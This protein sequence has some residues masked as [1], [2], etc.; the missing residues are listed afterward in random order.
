MIGFLF[1]LAIALP[2]GVLMGAWVAAI[3]E[4]RMGREVDRIF[5]DRKKLG[6]EPEPWVNEPMAGVRVC[7]CTGFSFS[8]RSANISDAS[9]RHYRDPACPFHGGAA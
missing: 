2:I 9:G 4:E 3:Y 6:Y 5:L 7:S 1:G 8:S